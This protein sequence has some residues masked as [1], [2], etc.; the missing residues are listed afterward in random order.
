MSTSDCLLYV[1]KDK[2]VILLVVIYADDL[3]IGRATAKRIEEVK[4]ML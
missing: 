2:A 1:P 3:I 4:N